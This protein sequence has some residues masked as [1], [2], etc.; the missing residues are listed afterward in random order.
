MGYLHSNL[1]QSPECGSAFSYEI[2]HWICRS[3]HT[4]CRILWVISSLL[5]R[6]AHLI[7]NIDLS[8]WYQYKELATRGSIFYSMTTIGGAFNGLIAYA[9]TKN[10]NGTGGWLAWRWIFLIEG[11]LPVGASFFVLFLLPD[12]PATTRFGFSEQER[13]MALARSMRAHNNFDEKLDYKKI[14]RPLKSL[15][16]WMMV[17]IACCN[18]FCS[19]SMSNFLP[20]IVQVR[21]L[22]KLCV[23]G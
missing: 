3:L 18:H 13:E 22:V 21:S 20:A 2:P 11:I 14:L 8:F 17:F 5:F 9:I 15:S 7:W 16:F 19:S 23:R 10:L 6:M 12:S 4:R 1:S